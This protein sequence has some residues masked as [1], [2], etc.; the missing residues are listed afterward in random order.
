MRPIRA[1]QP[2]RETAR[3]RDDELARQH[4]FDE[5][6]QEVELGNGRRGR[7]GVDDRQVGTRQREQAGGGL[8]APVPLRR[9]PERL[10][11]IGQP[12]GVN[13]PMAGEQLAERRRRRLGCRDHRAGGYRSLVLAP[14]EPSV[15]SRN[16]S[17][18][19]ARVTES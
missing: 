4:V 10:V 15:S 12:V 1:G 17:N 18:P 11:E 8:V 16:S 19:S 13:G 3:S 5:I 2:I 6:D 9:R 14:P 7:D